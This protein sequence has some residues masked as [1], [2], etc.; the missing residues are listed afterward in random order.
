MAS[1]G[2]PVVWGVHRSDVDA[3]WTKPRLAVAAKLCAK[4]T[5]VVPTRIVCCSE[6]AARGH[7]ALGYDG[8]RMVVIPNGF[9]LTAFKPDRDARR[10]VREELGIPIDARLIGMVA[11]F[12]P[13][14]DHETML[15]AASLVAD[16]HP[17]VHVI[18]CGAGVE[19]GNPSFTS[20]VDTRMPWER[21]HLLGMRRDIPR[22]DAA[23]DVAVLSSRSEAFPLAVGEAMA[24]GVPCV[25]TDVGD[26]A[27]LV[28][29]CGAVVPAGDPKR[30]ADAI[31]AL[32][33]RPSS[34]R[35][36]LGA[37]A[38]DHVVHSYEIG[39]IVARYEDLYRELAER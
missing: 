18:L 25:V 5:R 38:R 3:R 24:S 26:A 7:V 28:G 17:D 27:L 29:D 39:H 16:S 32:L 9:D 4:L 21:L 6:D 36:A 33:D 34:E 20:L 14:K 12:D 8:S 37:A 11:R 13:T 2:A 35:E 31:S 10:S 1:R 19:E 22:I 23:L 30:L 15:R